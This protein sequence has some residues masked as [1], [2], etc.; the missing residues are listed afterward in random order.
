MTTNIY[1]ATPPLK[2]KIGGFGNVANTWHSINQDDTQIHFETEN[3]G[4]EIAFL[5]S[6]TSTGRDDPRLCKENRLL[7]V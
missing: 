4:Q 7:Y 6:P 2:T 3:K 1:Y 5:I